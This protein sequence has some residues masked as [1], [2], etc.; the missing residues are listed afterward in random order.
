[1]G[2]QELWGY[3]LHLSGVKCFLSYLGLSCGFTAIFY[4]Y[5]LVSI[6]P[7]FL[8]DHLTLTAHALLA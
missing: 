1:M 5:I 8:F 2:S 7:R 6:P 4:T 3:S